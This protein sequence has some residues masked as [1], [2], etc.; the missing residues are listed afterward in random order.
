[1]KT[2]GKSIAVLIVLAVVAIVLNLIALFGIGDSHAFGLKSIKRGLDLNGGVSIVY[3]AD[4]E[5]VTDDDMRAAIGL[6]QSR[7]DRRN[8]T[9]A[10]VARQGSNRIRVEIPGVEDA[11]S[12]IEE[13]GKTAQLSFVDEEGN[14]I[15]TGDMIEEAHM[16]VGAVSMDSAS[17]PYVAIKF[18]EEGTAAFAEATRNNVGK[19]I[20]IV[21]DDEII[22]AP[23]VNSAIENG[24]AM[25]T[26][27][28]TGESAQELADLI[29]EGSM[30]F[31]LEVI[32]MNNIGARL[33]SNAISTSLMAAF[34]GVGLVLLF[35][36]IFYRLGGFAADWALCIYMG[37]EVIFLS[38]FN[39]T[40]T[41]P[42]IAGVI[43]SVGMAVD[44]NV[45][46]FERL[47]EE[48]AMGKT[49]RSAV[50]NSFSRAFPAI[51][52]GNITT[53]IAAFVLYFMGTGT[54]KGFAI[55]LMMGIILSMF[56]AIV[57]TRFIIMGII[58]LGIN[59]PRLFAVKPKLTV[60]E[61][62]NSNKGGN[63]K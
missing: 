14:I 4:K 37:L 29:Q 26:G 59:N 36:L 48:I 52:D 34:V 27:N 45:I 15:V 60:V 51:L 38:G 25:I 33:G 13:L 54:I 21:M 49:M 5:D 6:I 28:F 19:S 40:L 57:I 22:S 16:E 11:E 35:M 31:G 61:N 62:K 53:L 30:P 46:I 2:R 3:Q 12:A 24:E 9:E 20:L 47:K 7:L 44:A 56:T 8:W 41:L 55:T 50:R 18:N 63:E 1:M 58:G 17:S 32:E 10:E 39:V 42:G 43:L 23:I